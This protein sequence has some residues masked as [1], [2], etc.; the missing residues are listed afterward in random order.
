MDMVMDIMWLISQS[1]FYVSCLRSL[2]FL[3]DVCNEVDEH[4]Q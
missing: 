2:S 1:H 3:C 4:V